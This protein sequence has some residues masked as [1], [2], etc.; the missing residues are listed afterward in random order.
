MAQS[1]N[2][3]GMK[4]QHLPALTSMNDAVVMKVFDG[5]CGR[6]NDV[7]RIAVAS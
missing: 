2:W 3:V 7:G 4:N 1:Q 6:A 5:L